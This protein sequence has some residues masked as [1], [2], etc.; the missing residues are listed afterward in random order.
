MDKNTPSFHKIILGDYFSFYCFLILL[1]INGLSAYFLLTEKSDSGNLYHLLSIFWPTAIVPL[2]LLIKRIRSI[3]YI[4][5][6][7]ETVQG[8]I[9]RIRTN[10]SRRLTVNSRVVFSYR[11]KGHRYQRSRFLLSGDGFIAGQKIAV[12]ADPQKPKRA[13]IR[14]AFTD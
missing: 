5:S 8:K 13:F 14:S 12:I 6:F 4:F 7:G 9:E 11:L 3:R 2:I 1:L 10:T